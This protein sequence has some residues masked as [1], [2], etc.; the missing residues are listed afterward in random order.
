MTLNERDRRIVLILIPIVVILAYWFLLLSP[1]RNDLSKARDAQHSAETQRDAAVAQATQLEGARQSYAADYADLV[2][3]GKAIPDNVDA[4]S[5]LVQLSKAA[6]G[7]H[8]DFHS[9]SFGARQAAT[10]P[11]PSAPPP[12]EAYASATALATPGLRYTSP[13]ET[14]SMARTRS[15]AAWFLRT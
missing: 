8:I 7:T 13:R 12:G 11:A 1:K 2:R 15:R 4:P 14:P 10:A 5:L 3:L 9:I 6:S